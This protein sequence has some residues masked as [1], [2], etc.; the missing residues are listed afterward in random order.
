MRLT[1]RGTWDNL[2]AGAVPNTDD[3]RQL[4]WDDKVMGQAK[5]DFSSDSYA[6]YA[7]YTYRFRQNKTRLT[8]ID[9][10]NITIG[11][12]H[13]FNSALTAYD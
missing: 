3:T 4:L 6:F 8:E 1:L 13:P 5:L 12:S 11:A 10:H 9:W 7:V 2:T